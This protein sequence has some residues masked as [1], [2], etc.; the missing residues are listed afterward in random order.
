MPNH[1]SNEL[2]VSPIDQS[3]EASQQFKDFLKKSI[4]KNEEGD[5]IFTFNGAVPMPDDIFRGNLGQDE[6]EKYGDKNW[7]DWGVAHWGTKW[8]AYESEIKV[9]D[10]VG[11]YAVFK[12]Q[13]AW[14][15]PEEYLINASK[16]YP[17]LEF[18][19][20]YVLEGYEGCGRFRY[21][22]GEDN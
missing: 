12:F 1:T 9:T 17:K 8:D 13:T 16:A 19:L 14:S 7:Y 2:F 4:I 21:V 10:R 22:N 20:G 11:G 15:P 5:D 3:K 6:R 18:D